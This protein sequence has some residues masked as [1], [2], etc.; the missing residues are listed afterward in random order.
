MRAIAKGVQH[1]A[2][3]FNIFGFGSETSAIIQ[4]VKELFENSVDACKGNV[5]DNLVGNITVM[6]GSVPERND[7]LMIE[8]TD[9]G[10]GMQDPKKFLS[11]FESSK[12]S[13]DTLLSTGRF[14]VGLSTCLI[15]SLLNTPC[16]MRIVTKTR[17]SEEAVII[18]FKL[19][20]KGEPAVVQSKGVAIAELTCGTK[21]SLYVPLQDL[22]LL[23]GGESRQVSFGHNLLF[24]KCCFAP[25]VVKAIETVFVM[26]NAL[27]TTFIN[28][29]EC[30]QVYFEC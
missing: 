13:D 23:P 2:N 24:Y 12:G 15:Y 8:V 27:P 4:T 17:G 3:N 14:G 28:T 5:G 1:I 21:I 6:I 25:T 16:L 26:F 29:C 9:D 30:T 11:C 22:R 7:I 19:D 10:I 18:D 20:A